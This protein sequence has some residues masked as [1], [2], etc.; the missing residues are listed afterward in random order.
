VLLIDVPVPFPLVVADEF[1]RRNV[2]AARGRAADL[3]L[4]APIRTLTTRRLSV[5]SLCHRLEPC[6]MPDDKP[7]GIPA[8]ASRDV[9]L[10][11]RPWTDFGLVL[12]IHGGGVE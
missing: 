7:S 1:V 4:V 11:C 2:P 3:A 10:S 8:P 9:M 6:S 12:R 5:S